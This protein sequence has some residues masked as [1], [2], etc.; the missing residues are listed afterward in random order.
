MG[1]TNVASEPGIIGQ[2]YEERKSKKRGVLESRET[3]YKTLMMRAEDGRSFNITYATFKSNWRKYQGEDVIQTSTQ[4]EEQRV[5][6][7]KKEE[8]N[9]QIVETE[10]NIEKPA[11]VSKQDK[12]KKVRAVEE[13]VASKINNIGST[14]IKTTKTCKGCVIV[15]YKKKSLFEIWT[16][17]NLDKFDFCVL[18][19]V[20]KVDADKFKSVTDKSEYT[21]K[22][23]W[24]LPHLI[25]VSNEN[26]DSVVDVLIELAESFASNED[27]KEEK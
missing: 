12:V 24:H 16:K 6:E 21:L 5:E 27:S 1:T 3:K 11:K 10:S 15:Q 20:A 22:D 14:L 4:V 7:E 23:K 2:T 19:V 17:F 8:V 18:D 13:L 25:R 26:F 9:K